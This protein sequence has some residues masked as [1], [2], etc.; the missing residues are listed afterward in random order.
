[1]DQTQVVIKR[2]EEEN[3]SLKQSVE[4]ESRIA[5]E[6]LT[7]INKAEELLR[8]TLM[9][10]PGSLPADFETLIKEFLDAH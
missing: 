6:R 2:L 10:T 1:M 3:A 8:L 7:R 5:H 9:M 4:N